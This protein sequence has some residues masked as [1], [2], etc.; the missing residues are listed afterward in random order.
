MD[1]K[2]IRWENRDCINW[3]YGS[4]DEI[5]QTNC[6]CSKKGPGGGGQIG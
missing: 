4:A 1:L 6:G 5:R 3:T 2:E